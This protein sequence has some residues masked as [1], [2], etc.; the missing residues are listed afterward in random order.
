MYLVLAPDYPDF[1]KPPLE[2][3]LKI[4]AFRIFGLQ[5]NIPILNYLSAQ[6]TM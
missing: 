6:E 3:R 5:L 1:R 2:I 4:T